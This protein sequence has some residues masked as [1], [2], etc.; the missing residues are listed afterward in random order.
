MTVFTILRGRARMALGA[1]LL[2][3]GL[4]AA[5]GVPIPAQ[6]ASACGGNGERACCALER[7]GKP[8]DRGLKESGSCRRNCACG[9]G[10]GSSIG[11]CVRDDDDKPRVVVP[12]P[13][14]FP[15]PQQK[16]SACGGDGER[17]C[18][19]AERLPSCDTGLV[20]KAGCSGNCACGP[21]RATG[22]PVPGDAS[23][24]C[25]RP[26]SCGA[27][28]ERPC[29]LDVQIATRRTSCDKGLAEDVIANRCVDDSAAFREAQCRAIVGTLQAGKLPDAWRPVLD[30]ARQRGARLPRGDALAR[31]TAFVEPLKPLVPE[32]QRVYTELGKVTD[33]FR[34]ETLCSPA[35]LSAR[36]QQLAARLEPAV[37]QLLPTYSGRFHMAYTLNASA[38]AGPGVAAGYAVVTDYDGG[39]GVYVYLGP[40]LVANASLGDSLGVQ[41]YPKVTLDSF[42]GWGFGFGVAAGPPS[43]IFSGGADVAFTDRGV[44][45]GMG[46]GGGIGLGA[47]P[48]DIGVS[49]TYTWKIWSS[50]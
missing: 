50:R 1:L 28:G 18:C 49:A 17:A 4:L 11:M 12:P 33:L 42:E 6:A 36:L 45:V 43:L 13:P 22:V 5:L 3:C 25:T 7:P 24:T 29:T 26:P 41:F 2:G 9:K 16:T 21:N 34:A 23:G 20:E 48:V 14:T 37:K 39:V 30:E 8:C 31:G 44:P 27:K 19:A 40:S 32:L 38:A 15:A 46:I 35:R 47:L 10:P